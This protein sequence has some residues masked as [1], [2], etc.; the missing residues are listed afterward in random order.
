MGKYV[1]SLI[2]L[3]CMVSLVVAGEPPKP[4]DCAKT[5]VLNDDAAD[6]GEAFARGL[7]NRLALGPY[8]G[9]TWALRQARLDAAAGRTDTGDRYIAAV[10]AEISINPQRACTMATFAVLGLEMAN[11]F[12]ANI[13]PSALAAAI[14][15]QQQLCAKST[16]GKPTLAPKRGAT[17]NWL[18][19][20]FILDSC[21][22]SNGG[23][24]GDD[25]TTVLTNAKNGGIPLEADYGP[26]VAYNQG[27]QTMTGAGVL[28]YTVSDW[29]YAD[30]NSNGVG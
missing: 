15:L 1:L 20:Q 9:L 30:P 16:T 18:S 5:A 19:T 29:G 26:Y 23:C 2:V 22:G 28:L 12:G 8:R 21:C 25:N 14:A 10:Q 7:G 11:A 17:T 3:I 24:D 13:P 6:I 27:C 4:C